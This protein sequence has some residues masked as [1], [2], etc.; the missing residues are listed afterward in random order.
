MYFVYALR[1]E[2][3]DKTG[4]VFWTKPPKSVIWDKEFLFM[5]NLPSELPLRRVTFKTL[6]K[7]F[8]WEYFKT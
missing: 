1:S 3:D 8:K 5:D 7:N 6:A 4:I 2:L